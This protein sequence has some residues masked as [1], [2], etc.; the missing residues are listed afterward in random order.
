MRSPLEK[1]SRA[2]PLRIVAGQAIGIV[3]FDLST[4]LGQKGLSSAAADTA[5]AILVRDAT[6]TGL[7]FEP[8]CIK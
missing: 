5:R 4:G 6:A 3:I 8:S 1:P 2:R 7:S